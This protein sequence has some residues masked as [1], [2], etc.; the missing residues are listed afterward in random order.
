[1]LSLGGAVGA[2]SPPPGGG[3]GDRQNLWEAYSNTRAAAC[4]GHSS[5]SFVNAAGTLILRA[6]A[7]TSSTSS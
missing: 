3:R 5:S 2:Y 6:T 4:R 1:M 7:G